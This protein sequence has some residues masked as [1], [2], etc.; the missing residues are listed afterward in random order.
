M[1]EDYA[2]EHAARVAAERDADGLRGVIAEV[3]A[4]LMGTP[5]HA[6]GMW[7]GLGALARNAVRSDR[8]AVERWLASEREADELRRDLA[9]VADRARRAAQTII[10]E[11]GADGPMNVDEAADRIVARLASV[12]SERDAALADAK[13]LREREEHFARA[14]SVA[15]GGQY[16]NDWP[17]AIRRLL[18]E[19]DDARRIL[20]I[21]Q[22]VITDHAAQ[23]W[24]AATDAPPEEP[25]LVDALAAVAALRAE[26][27]LCRAALADAARG[28]VARCDT[29]HGGVLATQVHADG[30]GACDDCAAADGGGGWTDT[31]HAAAIR[32]ALKATEGKR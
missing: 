13:W 23:T 22:E 10:A 31:P 32:G 29:H 14:L 12:E 17:G 24:R 25:S 27:D 30:C 11:V 20:D 8:E 15:D 21:A 16:R 9:A 7:R 4:A 2:R 5:P 1:S 26:R 28:K 19:R 3:A 18:A 6:D